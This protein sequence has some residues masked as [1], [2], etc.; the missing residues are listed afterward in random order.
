[1]FPFQKEE[2]GDRKESDQS[3]TETQQIKQ[4]LQLRVKHQG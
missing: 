3:K 4:I 2:K 1:M